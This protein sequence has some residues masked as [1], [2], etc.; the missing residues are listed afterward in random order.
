MT[1]Q[2][3][4]F[5]NARRPHNPVVYPIKS[6]KTWFF[7]IFFRYTLRFVIG[8]H[9][10]MLWIIAASIGPD[11]LGAGTRFLYL[12]IWGEATE[13]SIQALA[14]GTCQWD[15]VLSCVLWMVNDGYYYIEQQNPKKIESKIPQ[16]YWII[17]FLSFWGLLQFTAWIYH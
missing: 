13:I 1:P 9:L 5:S 4:L 2:G 15:L 7:S 8:N 11:H 12:S 10:V 6:Q 3:F 16:T 17:A 14:G